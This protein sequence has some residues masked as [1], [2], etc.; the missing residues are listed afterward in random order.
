MKKFLILFFAVVACL[1]VF[2]VPANP[3]PVTVIQP[4]GEELTLMMN[5]DEYIRWAETMD[6][7]TL[8]INSEFYFCYAHRNAFG[9]L[10]PSPFIATEIGN[11]SH[12][13]STWLQNVNKKLFYSEEQVYHYMQLREI[14]ERELENTRTGTTGVNKIPVLLMQFSDRKFRKTSE[15]FDM[16]FNQINYYSSGFKGSFRD[17]F[18]ESSYN[19]LDLQSTIF[20]PFTLDEKAEYYV[21]ESKWA[22]YAKNSIQKAIAEGVDFSD[23]T[24]NGNQIEGIYIIYAGHDQSAGCKTCIWAHAQLSFNYSF[25]GYLFKRYAASSE[26]EGA[27]GSTLST[28]GTF[29]HE[30]GHVLGARDF[31]DTNYEIWGEYDGTGFWDLQASG[32]YNDGGKTPATPNPRSKITTYGWATA[33]ELNTPQRCTIPVSRIYEN[34][35]YRIN[36]PASNQYFILENKKKEGFDIGIPGENLLIY[37][38]TENYDAGGGGS[39]S[40]YPGNTTSWQRFYPV[41]ANAKDKVPEFGTNKKSQYGS[42]NAASCT[43]PQTNKTDFSNNSTPAMV[44]LDG[45]NVNKPITNIQVHDDFIT[46]D[47]I[48]GGSGTKS[49]YH[50][51]LPAY[52]GCMI[53]PQSGS[54]SPVNAGGNFSFKLDLLPTHDKSN[55]VVTSNHTPIVPFGGVYTISNIQADQ[56]VRIEGLQFN[57]FLVNATAGENGTITPNGEIYVSQGGLQSFEIKPENGYSINEVFIDGENK[58]KINS[59]IFKNVL[60]PHTISATFKKGDVYTIN[61]SISEAY[62]ETKTTVPSDV[63]ITTISSPDVIANISVNTSSSRFQVSNNGNQWYQAFSIPKNQ[64]PYQLYIRFFPQAGSWNEGTFERVLTLKSTEAYAEIKLIGVAGK[65]VNDNSNENTITVYPNPTTGK[66]R[67]ENEELR[68]ENVFIFDVYGRKVF[69]QKVEN[70]INKE[71]DI[72]NFSSGIYL[73]E[74]HTDKGVMHKKV[75]KE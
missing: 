58:G 15:D 2:A 18:L 71:I 9:D 51:F 61:T 75:V 10:E 11:R 21:P 47:F 42:I 46:F 16:L 7:Y 33:I 35:Y 13:V 45:T 22:T 14:N 5:G 1:Q 56:I 55:L 25:G 29:C 70:T 52:Y 64:L 43:W 53:T 41:S 37:R 34:A 60:E 36:T 30:Y 73:I 74:I 26:L 4:N 12:E 66:L 72:T 3:K 49:D 24:V 69:E 6:G 44:T 40:N 19:K 67:I 63:V 17:F 8:L 23:F 32:S 28:I 39:P 38:C 20:G 68:M 54:I 48:G 57:T 62:F 31:Y 65:G 50:V 27:S 59:Y